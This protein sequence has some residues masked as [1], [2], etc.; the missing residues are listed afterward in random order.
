MI[1]FFFN[2]SSNR[3]YSA[4][5]GAPC[6][7]R[8]QWKLDEEREGLHSACSHRKHSFEPLDYALD[9]NVIWMPTDQHYNFEAS[10]KLVSYVGISIPEQHQREIFNAFNRLTRQ[11]VQKAK[12]SRGRRNQR[13]QNQQQDTTFLTGV[14]M[15]EES[16][17]NKS[18]QSNRVSL[19]LPQIKAAGGPSFYASGKVKEPRKVS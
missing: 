11:V 12:E 3:P 1:L 15:S 14:E 2:I 18:T 8:Q 4:L 7:S 13:E 10:A 17:Q 6:I 9:D 19:A 16:G 5:E